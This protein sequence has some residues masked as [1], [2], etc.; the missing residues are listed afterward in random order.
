V[1]Q[2]SLPRL[3]RERRAVLPTRLEGRDQGLAHLAPHPRGDELTGE[4]AGPDGR[5]HE[6]ALQAWP[7]EAARVVLGDPVDVS[8]LD[9]EERAHLVHGR[10]GLVDEVAIAHDQH[11]FAGHVVV[12]VPELLAVQTEVAVAPEGCPAG[13]D[14]LLLEGERRLEVRHRLQAVGPQVHPVGVRT[15]DRV[16]HDGDQAHAR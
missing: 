14:A 15:V 3:R 9:A 7:G 12:E 16:A 6:P 2:Q 4:G 1:R 11:V 13:V 5:S 8:G 10:A